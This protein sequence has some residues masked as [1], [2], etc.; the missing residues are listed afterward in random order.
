[1]RLTS[2]IALA[3]VV[4]GIG[5]VLIF[6]RDWLF[7]TVEKG[8]QTVEG[9]TP[10][11]SAREAADLYIKAI[12]ARNY[13]AAA[14]YCNGEYGIKLA[15]T[16]S[17]ANDLGTRIDREIAYVK[18]KGFMK[19]KTYLVLRGLD[20]YPPLIKLGDFKEDTDKSKAVAVLALDEDLLSREAVPDRDLK[21]F[22]ANFVGVYCLAPVTLNRQ[23]QAALEIKSEGEGEEKQFKIHYTMPEIQQKAITYFVEHYKGYYEGLGTFHEEVRQGHFLRDQIYD[24]LLRV[25][26]AGK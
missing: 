6:K 8:I 16:H 13:K 22:D 18:E 12:K 15:K 14:L 7:K 25:V 21:T 11:K 1:M 24:E 20:P 2:L 17:E 10:A 4:G 5:Y 19:D 26:R 23:G 3:A 9:Y